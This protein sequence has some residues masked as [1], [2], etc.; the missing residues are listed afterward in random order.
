MRGIF[1][2]E[3]NANQILQHPKPLQ[4]GWTGTGDESD[5]YSQNT[6]SGIHLHVQLVSNNSW[7]LTK[8]FACKILWF[9]RGFFFSH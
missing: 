3:M 4:S 9:T 1:Q 7:M 8:H 6:S 2:N 5:I